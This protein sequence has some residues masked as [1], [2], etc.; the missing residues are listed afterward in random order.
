MTGRY[1]RNESITNCF[2]DD[3]RA[4]HPR[5]GTVRKTSQI[6][7]RA[8]RDAGASSNHSR[9]ARDAGVGRLFGIVAERPALDFGSDA[10]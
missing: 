1:N 8:D 5:F 2:A 3:I 4:F 7:S 6:R 10:Q 9:R